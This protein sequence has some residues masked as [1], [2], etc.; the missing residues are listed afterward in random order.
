MDQMIKLIEIIIW[1]LLVLL[2]YVFN[3]KRLNSVIDSLIDRIE[4]GATFKFRGI[5]VGEA[6]LSLPTPELNEEVAQ[7]HLALVHSSWRYPRKDKEFGKK[8]YG[9]QLIVQGQDSVLDRIEYV[10][11]KLHQ[12]YP[13]PVQIKYDRK[14]HFELKELAWGESTVSAEVKIKGQEMTIKLS[15]YINLAETGEKLII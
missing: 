5:E 14:R 13:N 4:A 3:F 2:I 9:F 6:P 11:Y 10:K 1:P 8:M 7:E 15:R 12:T